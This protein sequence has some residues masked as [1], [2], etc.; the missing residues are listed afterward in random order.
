[1]IAISPVTWGDIINA[2]ILIVTAFILAW[3]AWIVRRYTIAAQKSN[4]I[5]ERPI[6]NL[7]LRDGEHGGGKIFKVR[8]V[9]NGP[10][11]N[12]KLSD[13]EVGGYMYC[14]YF[15]EPNSILERIHDE[16]Q[17]NFEVKLPDSAYKFYNS[18]LFFNE[19]ESSVINAW[20]ETD[21]KF[22]AV[23]LLSYTGINSK[24]YY[25]LFRVYPVT[26]HLRGYDMVVEFIKNGEGGMSV[27]EAKRICEGQPI[28]K[29]NEQ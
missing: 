13:I 24:I 19:F 15:D 27:D 4:E 1:M 7:Y 25:S 18:P 26:A 8:N 10:A 22:F 20:I 29:K 12:I 11:Y 17:I 23:Y 3:T 2:V 5:Q 16:R 21:Q 28:M 6:L 14:P 9:G